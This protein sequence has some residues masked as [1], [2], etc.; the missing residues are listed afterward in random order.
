MP[1]GIP[2]RKSY[3]AATTIAHGGLDPH[4]YHGFVN[5]PVVHASTVLSPDV[6]TYDRTDRRYTYGFN[7]PTHDALASLVAELEGAEAAV[8]TSS[9]LSACTLPIL[10]LVEAGDH[11]VVVD[12][13]YSPTRRFCNG[14]LKRLGIA[15]TYV[16]PLDEAAMRRALER[17]T[18]IVF[19]EA[20]GSLTFEM[21]DVPRQ[22]AM[23]KEASAWTI[24][25]NT[26]ATPL[27][28]APLAHGCDLSVQAGTKY[29]AGHSDLLLGT[30]AGNGEAIE[31]VRACRK[32]FGEHV[33][34]DDVYLT[35]RGM[36]TLDVRLERHAK[37]AR[38]VAERLAAHPSVHR[39]LYP[40]LPDAPG[41]ALWRRDFSGATGLF[42]ITLKGSRA[43]AMRVVD[44]LTL[45]GIG[46]S[47]GG[48]E[49][50]VTLPYVNKVRSAT[51]WPDDEQVVRLNIGLEDPQDLIDDLAQ[52]LSRL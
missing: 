43:E 10:A 3:R 20:P 13:V 32:E 6:A 12:N 41:H 21:P 52:A 16:D 39:V 35:L 46:A 38:I 29:F 8:L 26:W 47:W 9:G 14:T 48:F 4:A 37:N 19:L 7:T 50:L 33:A 25:D 27:Y 40:A 22:I 31:R 1:D 49:S 42:A 18:R 15:T 34:A 23:A 30:V 44:A 2:E 5:P 28:F 11:V 51:R 24:M 45:F 36:R 17:P